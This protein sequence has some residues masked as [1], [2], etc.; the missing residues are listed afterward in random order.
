MEYEV[1]RQTG[2][3]EKGGVI[4]QETRGWDDAKQKTISQ[5]TKEDA[6]DYRYFADPDLPPVSLDSAYIDAVRQSMPVMPDAWRERLSELGLDR[7]QTDVLLEAEIEDEAVNYLSLIE[8]SLSNQDF[9]RQ[10][11]NWFVNLEIPLRNRLT[12]RLAPANIERHSFYAAVYLLVQEQKLSSTNAKALISA[13]LQAGE[14]PSDVESHAAN[15]GYI[16]VS[17]SA[18][19]A[20]VVN[21]VLAANPKAAQD[22]VAGEA[23]AIGFLVGQVMKQ[24]QGKANPQLAQQLIR[25][26]LGVA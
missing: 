6:H 18:A 2:L 24:S 19:I 1:S 4:V 3:L 5:R 17:D 14:Y 12:E 13:V 16:Q 22:V 9:A 15:L 20:E 7:S 11:S 21:A 23:K 10:L 25:E 26:H 8:Q